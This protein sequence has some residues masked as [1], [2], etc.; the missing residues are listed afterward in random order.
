M[1]LVSKVTG[2]T[3]YH[4]ELY[5]LNGKLNWTNK[6]LV[7]NIFRASEWLF[8]REY[9]I[10]AE[11]SSSAWSENEKIYAVY[12]FYT[13]ESVVVHIEVMIRYYLS[14]VYKWL[15]G[16][17]QEPFAPLPRPVFLTLQVFGAIL[18]IKTSTHLLPLFVGAIAFDDASGDFTTATSLT[19]SH[20]C[21]GSNLVLGGPSAVYDL[22]DAGDDNVT[23]ETYNAVALT[24]VNTSQTGNNRGYMYILVNPAT[25][26]HDYVISASES[27]ILFGSA[28]SYSGCSQTG[29][30]N[31]Q[32]A[33]SAVATNLTVSVTTTADNCWLVSS[34]RNN[35]G[36]TSPVA[37]TNTTSRFDMSGFGAGDSNG[38]NT[39]PGSF[40]QAWTTNGVPS[41]GNITVCVMA[42][43]PPDV[44]R[45]ARIINFV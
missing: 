43:K 38:A 2:Q 16:L 9:G 4:P 18:A 11:N 14:T 35:Q 17:S 3:R 6:I 1:G 29:Q 36:G 25:G 39:P 15:L 21:T 10:R 31:A 30:P 42:I 37:G 32:N 24:R 7:A 5:E 22:G 44:A 8:G 13:L 28:Q 19:I 23:G 33:Q 45:G 34:T 12:R 40:G 26:A 20:T 41:S 27:S